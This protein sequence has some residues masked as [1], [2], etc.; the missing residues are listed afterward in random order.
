MSIRWRLLAAYLLVILA[1]FGALAFFLGR[2]VIWGA[3]LIAL[4]AVLLVTIGFA[5]SMVGPLRALSDAARRL[6]SGDLDARPRVSGSAEITALCSALNDMASRL[7]ALVR[8]A[9]EEKKRAYTI[10][11]GLGDA[12]IV[13]DSAGRITLCNAAA[14]R[15]FGLGSDRAAGIAVVDATQSHTLD[16]AFRQVLASGGKAPTEV[17]VLFP[18]PRIMEATVTAVAGEPPLGAVAV[19]RDVT[20][21]RRLEAVRRDFV[22]NASHELQTPIT[23]IKALAETLLAGGKDD[24]EVAA[25]FLNDLVK[26]AD[27]LSALVRDLLDLAAIESGADKAEA[28]SANAGEVAQSVAAQLGALAEQRRIGVEVDV[29]A[30]V[31]V[32]AGG[33]ALARILSNLLDNAIKYTEPGG[34]AGIRAERRGDS[35]AITVWDTGIGIPSTDLRHVFE[36]FY[37]VDKARSRELGGTG[38][39]LSIVRHLAESLGGTVSAQSELGRGSRFTLTL[40]LSI[41]AARSETAEPGN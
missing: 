29:P 38:L 5:H 6:A 28:V 27:R 11:E 20:D 33:Q 15:V 10:L 35:V 7:K 17:L 30:D 34:K 4:V 41:A 26:Q 31:A 3:G 24:A 22:A 13:S 25:R 8:E 1:A 36:R 40:P 32:P 12:V 37:R 19:L 39:G 14:E 9:Q 16:E 23:A 2:A 21:V 18:R